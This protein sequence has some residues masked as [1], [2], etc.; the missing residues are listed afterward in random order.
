MIVSVLAAFD[1]IRRATHSFLLARSSVY[2][3]PLVLSEHVHQFKQEL[4]SQ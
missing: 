4:S 2:G 3:A 1:T